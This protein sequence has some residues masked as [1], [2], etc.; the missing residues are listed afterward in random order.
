MHWSY[1]LLAVLVACSF[2]INADVSAPADAPITDTPVDAASDAAGPSLCTPG[3]G[4]LVCFAFDAPAFGATLANEGSA[5]VT[6]Q[7]SGVTR[8]ARGAGGAVM[9]DT[10]SQ[11]RIPPNPLTSGI[12]ATEAWV[13]LDVP[14]PTGS[15][16]GL[17]DADA[18]SSAVSF[19]FYDGTPSRQIRFELG[20]QL[21][22]DH[23]VAVGT[24]YYLAQVC[25]NNV[26]TAYVDGLAIGTR[27]GC[28]PGNSTTYGLQFGQNNNQ[29]GGDQWMTGAIDGIRMWTTPRTAKQICEAAGLTSC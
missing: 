1:G 29:T 4:L 27:T 14:P 15:R 5:A 13:R 3:S 19:F 20:Q 10:S 23:P 21:F 7:V 18:T 26:L 12:V 9:V 25:E 28:S 22:L 6:A 16:V 17:I 2:R 8:I 11:I 24:W